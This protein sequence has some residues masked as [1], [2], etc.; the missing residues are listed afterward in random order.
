[1]HERELHQSVVGT[2]ESG[3]E[4]PGF[5]HPDA[6]LALDLTIE[7]LEERIQLQKK[8]E[9]GGSCGSSSSCS[10]TWKN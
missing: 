9:G 10:P 2:V 5:A 8:A 3:M 7:E 4:Q 1:M 6:M